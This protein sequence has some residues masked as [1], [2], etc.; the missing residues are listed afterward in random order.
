MAL[1]PIL[2]VCENVDSPELFI[3]PHTSLG[4]ARLHGCADGGD[5]E[6]DERW[7]EP[8]RV[9]EHPQRPRRVHSHTLRDEPLQP[10]HHLRPAT[11]QQQQKLQEM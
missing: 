4:L 8:R 6:G 7:V 9:L 2:C 3:D 10:L 5:D 11:K 1:L